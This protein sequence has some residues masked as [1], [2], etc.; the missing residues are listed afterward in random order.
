MSERYVVYKD[1]DGC[2]TC[3][4]GEHFTVLDTATDTQLSTS[5]ED[6]ELAE[7]ICGWMNQAFEAGTQEGAG[8]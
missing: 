4:H 8:K 1:T 7:D 3:G 2:P 6:K 5:Y